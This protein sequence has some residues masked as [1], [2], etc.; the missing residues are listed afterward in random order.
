MY[1]ISRNT[2]GVNWIFLKMKV[3]LLNSKV[4]NELNKE[5]LCFQKRVSFNLI[6][7]IAHFLLF[8]SKS[9]FKSKAPNPWKLNR[10]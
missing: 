10:H 4:Q 6:A 2:E 5:C 8:H 1:K 3:L 9:N 7:D